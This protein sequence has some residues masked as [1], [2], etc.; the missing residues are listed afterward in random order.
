[1]AFYATGLRKVV[2][3]ILIPFNIDRYTFYG[4]T[5]FSGELYV[6]ENTSDLY[7]STSAWNRFQTIVEMSGQEENGELSLELS[8]GRIEEGTEEQVKLKV[9]RSGSWDSEETV[10][11]KATEDSRV[12]VPPTIT[13]PAR[14]SGAV[15]Y[16]PVTNNDVVDRDSVV[17]ITAMSDKLEAVTARLVIEDDEFPPLTVTASK[18][19]V[20]EGETF[21]LTV[22]TSRASATPIEVTLTSENS[23]RFSYPR[24]ATIPAG[25]T[26]VVVDVTAKNDDIPGEAQSVAFTASAPRYNQGE[27]IVLLEDDDMPVL[28]LVLTPNKVQE[29]AGPVSVAGTLRRT[30][31]TTNKITVRLSDDS[32]GGLY[33]G[34]RELVLNKGVEEASFNFGPI[35]NALA[36]GDRTCTVTAAVWLSSCSCSAAGESAG[37]VSAQLQV[38]DDDGPALTLSSTMSTI[39]EGDK[40]TLT[41]SRN[42]LSNINQP[43]TVRLG[44]DYDESLTYAHTVTI[45]AG[46]QTAQVEITSTKNDVSGDSHTVVFTV[47]ADGFA[48]GTCWLMVTD[49]TL[50]D[51]V[52]T[53]FTIS[54]G[55]VEAGGTATVSITVKNGGSAVLPAQTKVDFFISGSNI[56]IGTLYTSADIAPGGSASMTKILRLPTATDSKSLY[57]VVN[58]S[59]EV[60]ELLYTNN[61]SNYLDIQ[62]SSPYRTTVACDKDVYLPGETI[63]LTG[64]VEG[65]VSANSKVEIYLINDGF[66]Q[67]LSTV[68]DREGKFSLSYSPYEKQMGHFV[69]GACYPGE[70]ISTEQGA[71]DYMG[72]RRTSQKYITCEVL[73]GTPYHGTIEVEN[74]T[75]LSQHNIRAEVL[76]APE[77]CSISFSPASG[78]GAGGKYSLNYTIEGTA[79]FEGTDWK[80]IKVRIIS[81]EGASTE[82]SL[83]CYCRLP[84]AQLALDVTEMNTTVTKGT[85]RDYPIAITNNGAGETGRITLSLPSLIQT[86]TSQSVSS[87]NPGETATVLLRLTTTED[88]PLNVP[89]TGQIG[90][91]CENGNGIA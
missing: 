16:L 8:P 15:A 70:D 83:Y 28:Q 13:I 22:S 25:Q 34:T 41:V 68:T 54:S 44:S 61:P 79:A 18:S 50:P 86:A 63:A 87:I 2:S 1:M 90:I 84:E 89:Y 7:R 46:Q 56:S 58:N 91:N 10:M 14:Q 33:F 43:L 80:S 52:I 30:G 11:L 81:D 27:A 78:I 26:S 64:K 35:D 72:L 75:G 55:E 37:S 39:K 23:K 76:S 73:V 82:V 65:N 71:F 19:V 9:T 49:Q 77:N 57:C 42:T 17:E 5:Y 53:D 88:M 38:L 47:Q 21:Q 48:S 4:S 45:P 40:A 69:I 60:P 74:P 31:V 51:A 6:P 29:G 85:P 67:T 20:N 62:L 3:K 12:T 36:D 32:N 66:R 59:M 24:K